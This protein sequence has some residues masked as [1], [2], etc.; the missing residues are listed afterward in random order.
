MIK[1]ISIAVLLLLVIAESGWILKTKY[2]SMTSDDKAP[3]TQTRTPPKM[4]LKG[5][6]L[7]DSQIAKNAYK[8]FP[9]DLSPEATA[10]M[11]GFKMTSSKLTDGSTEVTLTP[12]EQDDQ[13]QVYTVNAGESLFFVELS[14][15]DDKN[16]QEL[17][18]RDD[19]GIITDASGLVL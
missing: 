13:K 8:I 12:T 1:N 5:D 14:M 3:V 10:A 19:Y 17:N 4:L 9:G 6:K 2:R 7:A 11:V 15:F 18:L 16:N